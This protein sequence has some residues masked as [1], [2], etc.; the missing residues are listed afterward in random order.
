LG[1]VEGIKEEHA[2]LLIQTKRL[3]MDLEGLDSKIGNISGQVG[4]MLSLNNN[5]VEQNT[6][7]INT[8]THMFG[9]MNRN[10]DVLSDRL[11][12]L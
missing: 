7:Q 1:I 11:I 5:K 2:N 12:S 9:S 3:R 10:F 6:N 4:M 8:L